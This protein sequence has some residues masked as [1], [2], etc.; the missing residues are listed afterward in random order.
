MQAVRRQPNPLPLFVP[1]PNRPRGYNNW[2]R[3]QGQ[4]DVENAVARILL[5]ARP[6]LP[7]EDR[8]GEDINGNIIND[9]NH[10]Q[11]INDGNDNDLLAR[12][13]REAVAQRP[14]EE[15]HVIFFTAAEME[16]LR[17]GN[18]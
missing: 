13:I 16:D 14:M 8:Q 1:T 12:H 10:N 7:A 15:I 4:E 11:N 5:A 9:N 3:Q 2:R 6:R 17:L 18:F